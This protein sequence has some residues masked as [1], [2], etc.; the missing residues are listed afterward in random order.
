MVGLVIKKKVVVKFEIV[1]GSDGDHREDLGTSS[2][3]LKPQPPK[4]PYSHATCIYR[5]EA[6]PEIVL[7]F[8]L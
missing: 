4:P 8:S 7:L 3:S 1:R 5:P 2:F 6:A